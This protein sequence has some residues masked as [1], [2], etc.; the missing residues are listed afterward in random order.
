MTQI[1]S[2]TKFIGISSD[3]PTP[4]NRSAQN[5][6]LSEMYT[7]DDVIETVNSEY[8]TITIG[9]QS[10]KILSMG[11]VPVEL[12]PAP[13]NGRYYEY[14]IAYEFEFGTTQYTLNDL[15]MVGGLLSYSGTNFDPSA[16]T[17]ANDTVFFASNFVGHQQSFAGS[18]QPEWN[19]ATHF[20]VNE[21]IGI[22]TFGGTDPEDGDGEMRAKITY[23]ILK[24]E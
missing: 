7:I 13:G 24:F 3:V 18:S 10:N 1:P 5:N 19:R 9:I 12:L 14:K 17:S 16:I 8:T 21:P 15:I 6:A 2:G 4:E 20:S 23:R 11:T 22:T